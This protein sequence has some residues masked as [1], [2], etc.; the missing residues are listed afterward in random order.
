MIGCRMAMSSIVAMQRLEMYVNRQLSAGM[1]AEAA[2]AT[3]TIE[4]GDGRAS[5]RHELTDSD[6]MARVRAARGT[7]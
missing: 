5:Q 3:M 6:M 4:V 7:P 2:G 1:V